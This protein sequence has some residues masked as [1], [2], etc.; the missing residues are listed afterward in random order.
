MHLTGYRSIGDWQRTICIGRANGP[1]GSIDDIRAGRAVIGP[2]V[3]VGG[4]WRSPVLGNDDWWRRTF[5]CTRVSGLGKTLLI[6]GSWQKQSEPL[7][8]V[9]KT[10]G[11]NSRGAK[12]HTHHQNLVTG[13][14]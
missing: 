14:N 10:D 12:K 8:P 9:E 5:Q 7:G 13:S 4:H 2:V 11:A 3:G 6:R 1:C